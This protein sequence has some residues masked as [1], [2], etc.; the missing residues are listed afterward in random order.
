LWS[1]VVLLGASLSCGVQGVSEEEAPRKVAGKADDTNR[2]SW[3][4]ITI[5]GD[6]D[7]ESTSVVSRGDGSAKNPYVIEALKIK[8]STMFGGPSGVL[9]YIKD[10]TKHFR[11]QKNDLSVAST[12]I[13]LENVKNGVITE[14]EIH[15]IYGRTSMYWSESGLP[16]IGVELYSCE[17]IAVTNNNFR[18]ITGGAGK[19]GSFNAMPHFMF[20]GNEGGDGGNGGEAIGVQ[21]TASRD[22]VISDNRFS[23]VMGGPGNVGGAG[24]IG[25][26]GGGGGDGGHGGHVYGVYLSSASKVTV[27]RNQFRTLYGGA[28]GAGA[29]GAKGTPG[30]GG[31]GGRGG[32]GGSVF[33][34][35]VDTLPRGTCSRSSSPSCDSEEITVNE[36]QFI[37]QKGG[38]GA[39]GAVGATGTLAAG[40]GGD[41]GWGGN[42]FLLDVSDTQNIE[43]QDN[44]V[45]AGLWGGAGGAGGIGATV[46]LEL[47]ADPCGLLHGGKA[48]KG[49]MPGDVAAARFKRCT[50]VRF[51][52]NDIR[53]LRGAVGAAS[54]AGAFP[55][56]IGGSGTRGGHAVGALFANSSLITCTDNTVQMLRGGRGAV[57]SAGAAG[58]VGCDDHPPGHGGNGGAGA[59]TVGLLYQN[60]RGLTIRDNS[61]SDLKGGKGGWGGAGGAQIDSEQAVAKGGDGGKGGDAVG[62]LLEASS[63]EVTLDGNT[64][65]TLVSEIGGKGSMGGAS[66]ADGVS[67]DV[68]QSDKVTASLANLGQA[69]NTPT[70]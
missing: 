53:E 56:G 12:A 61:V 29:V 69:G 19:L 68:V 1:L 34:I 63:A 41:A 14:N 26:S 49:G 5:T 38:A 65:G 35:K 52:K 10:T 22:V 18:T 32:D 57:G 55:K 50:G 46:G 54:A 58:K 51:S 70:K 4:R 60:C 30:K 37:D 67:D 47:V 31:D 36:N 45:S 39:A 25:F 16:G 13:L 40:A 24:N 15:G 11:L 28:G 20:N 66:G 9:I 3:T 43:V 44:S 42:V 7:F 27:T 17:N 59:D 48:G 23:Y 6:A 62:I 33:G 8:G 64:I 2:R 21:T